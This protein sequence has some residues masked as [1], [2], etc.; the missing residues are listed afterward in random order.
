[1]RIS[2]L[3]S[4]MD[5]EALL[6]D[7]MAAERIPVDRL[8]Q[9]KVKMEWKRDAYRDANAKLLRLR[10][11][12]FDMTLQGSYQMRTAA[13]SHENLVTAVA[14]G[15]SM[16]G[17]LDI[18]VRELAAT[19]RY[20]SGTGVSNKL[21]EYF[22]SGG[23]KDKEEVSIS[24][25]GLDNEAEII[26]IKAGDS[27]Q[28]IVKQINGNKNLSFSAYYDEHN[29]QIAFTTKNTGSNAEITVIE[30]S[31]VF[32]A[33]FG[34]GEPIEANP[35]GHPVVYSRGTNAQVTINGLLTERESNTFEVNGTRVTLHEASAGTTVRI[36]VSHDVDAVYDKI[37]EFVDL[38]N[39]IVEELNASL[40]EPVNREYLPLTDAQ[41]E[42]MTEKEI[43]RW[44]EAAKSGLL[45]SD[46]MVSG[47]LSELRIALGAVVKGIDGRSSLAQ[48]GIKTGAW[49]EH[50]VLHIDE[51][52]V[53]DALRENGEEVI[54]LFTNNG[55]GEGEL[56]IARRITKVLDDGMERIV[57]TAG[58][59]SIPYDQSYLGEQIRR[60]ETRIE[61]MEERLIRV[62]QRYWNQF[63]AMEKALS[64]L[65]AQS[66]WMYQQLTALQG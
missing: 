10:N 6:N 23:G 1:M 33:V 31:D 64:E 52:K 48:I 56:G 35:D 5:T 49:Y 54:A 60:Y 44:E 3:S 46:R 41:K 38:Y 14:T 7:I 36:N 51:V 22:E 17:V 43:E 12:A 28:D 19:G 27:V 32:Q 58:K 61:D 4:G 15:S 18:E 40:R 26:T 2:G 13:S 66:D 20:Q 47:I 9:Q 65:Y 25:R 29:D 45:R 8:F 62:E 37:K 21:T 42:A 57:S 63:I 11:F 50:G 34:G 59:A 30:G 55:T 53:K 39:E 24:F 16:D